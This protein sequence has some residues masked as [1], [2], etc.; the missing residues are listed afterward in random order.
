MESD[1]R[2][3]AR[4]H[5]PNP[6]TL[7]IPFSGASP[8]HHF[9]LRS[10]GASYSDKQ[11]E[12][13]TTKHLLSLDIDKKHPHIKPQYPETN[14][15]CSASRTYNRPS[16]QGIRRLRVVLQAVRVA[17]KD[18][19]HITGTEQEALGCSRGQFSLSLGG[20]AKGYF[21]RLGLTLAYREGERAGAS[22]LGVLDATWWQKEAPHDVSRVNIILV[23]CDVEGLCC[24]AHYLAF[25]LSAIGERQIGCHPPVGVR[26]NLCNTSRHSN[27]RIR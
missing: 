1:S 3:R 15:C 16:Q 4:W 12:R 25:G 26:D 18:T 21:D 27:V 7:K 19:K 22:C 23:T 9:S 20:V 14:S 2:E 6:S 17:G 24:L 11:T 10:S 5:I 8:R 13:C